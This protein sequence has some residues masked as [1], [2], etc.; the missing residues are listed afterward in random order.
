MNF[1]ELNSQIGRSQKPSPWSQ[2]Q[3]HSETTEKTPVAASSIITA[4]LLVDYAEGLLAEA[5][6]TT[7]SGEFR[8]DHHRFTIKQTEGK[9][10]VDHKLSRKKLEAK[11]KRGSNFTAKCSLRVDRS[12]TQT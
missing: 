6:E 8:Q 7:T 9:E 1:I 2:I 10:P 11:Q 5:S 12:Q 4:Y 3:I